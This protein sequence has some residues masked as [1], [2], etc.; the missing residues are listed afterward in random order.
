MFRVSPKKST[1]FFFKLDNVELRWVDPCAVLVCKTE[2]VFLHEL[3]ARSEA[4]ELEVRR[5]KDREKEL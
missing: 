5:G 2:L 3:V 4:I 1:L